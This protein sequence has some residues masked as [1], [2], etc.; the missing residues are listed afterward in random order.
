M[1]R[2]WKRIKFLFNVKQSIPFLVDFFKSGD[3]PFT[4]KFFSI[5]LIVGYFFLPFDLIPDFLFLLGIVD[6]V[7]VFTL[8]LQQIV[9]MAPA[10]IREKH[11]FD[12]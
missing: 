7:T 10:W 6:D 1:W 11:G 12:S 8:V 4:R 2:F 5:A 3:V 9:K